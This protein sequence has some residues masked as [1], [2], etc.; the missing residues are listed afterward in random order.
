MANLHKF[1]VQEVLNAQG[2]GGIWQRNAVVNSA[3]LAGDYANTTN[4]Q[5]GTNTHVL[6][7]EVGGSSGLIFNFSATAIECE[8]LDI[9]LPKGLHFI[10]I[11]RGLGSTI[12]LNHVS[13]HASSVCS[14]KTV[15]V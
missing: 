8:A 2:S 15:E 4:F 12:Y 9:I 11:P 10:T 7:I 13:N 3:A 5:L 14:V 1:T 6:G